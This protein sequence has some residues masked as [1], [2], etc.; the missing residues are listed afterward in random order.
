MKSTE[1]P[2]INIRLEPETWEG[3]RDLAHEFKTTKT[4]IVESALKV[5]IADIK[6]GR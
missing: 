1:K 4:A 3:L 5:L 6:K 2:Q